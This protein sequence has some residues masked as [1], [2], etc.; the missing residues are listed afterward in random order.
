MAAQAATK[1]P[2]PKDSTTDGSTGSDFS[3]LCKDSASGR[4][5]GPGDADAASMNGQAVDLTHITFSLGALASLAVDGTLEEAVN[6]IEQLIRENRELKGAQ[7]LAFPSFL[8]PTLGNF[9]L[10]YSSSSRLIS[11]FP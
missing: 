6:I 7:L 11:S 3:I 9:T 4:L 5:I 1:T 10:V 2:S 8:L